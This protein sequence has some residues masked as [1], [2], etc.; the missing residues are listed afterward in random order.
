MLVEIILVSARMADTEE[1]MAVIDTLGVDINI[2]ADKDTLVAT[3]AISEGIIEAL[4][5][6]DT[7]VTI[8]ILAAII[9]VLAIAVILSEILVDI[10]V[11][12]DK[13]TIIILVVMV[14]HPDILLALTHLT[15]PDTPGTITPAL[16]QAIHQDIRLVVPPTLA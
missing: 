12:I 2:L 11:F 7:S 5:V 15:N 14:T 9:H 6:A 16:T 8:G 4:V 13:T 3:E 10:V 1:T